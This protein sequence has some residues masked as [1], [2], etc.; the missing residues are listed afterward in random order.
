MHGKTPLLQIIQVHLSLSDIS[1]TLA[2][3]YWID[4]TRM[5][6]TRRQR[7][8]IRFWKKEE[9]IVRSADGWASQWEALLQISS[10][11]QECSRTLLLEVGLDYD[12]RLGVGH[13]SRP[14]SAGSGSRNAVDLGN[15]AVRWGRG[16]GAWGRNKQT[17][18]CTRWAQQAWLGGKN[19]VKLIKTIAA[20]CLIFLIKDTWS[21]F[22]WVTLK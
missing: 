3:S 9:R 2:R 5:W 15:R 1:Y 11:A 18:T 10:L 17:C 14:A 20:D 7:K 6:K 16:S 12:D 21:I 4:N 22:E 8:H 19:N 13:R